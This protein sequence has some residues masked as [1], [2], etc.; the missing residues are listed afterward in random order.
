MSLPDFDY[1]R[2]NESSYFSSQG[3]GRPN[4]TAHDRFWFLGKREKYMSSNRFS[5]LPL[6]I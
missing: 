4:I 2:L 1:H 5:Y 6:R 3:N